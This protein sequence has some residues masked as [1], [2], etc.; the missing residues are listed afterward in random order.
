MS[1]TQAARASAATPGTRRTGA[2]EQQGV[3]S[4]PDEVGGAKLL[5][6]DVRTRSLLTGEARRR[7]V[8]RVFGVP[9][10][11]QSLLVT[12][13]LIGAVGTVLR[14]FAAALPRPRPSGADAAIGGSL[15]NATFR[16]IAGA[17]SRNMPLAGGLIAFAVLSHSLRPAVA[18]SARTAH[19]VAHEVRTVFGARYG[20]HLRPG[21]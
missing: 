8:T 18:G 1:A 11:D 10:A 15:L 3:A 19:A 4:K 9:R 5:F 2:R 17:P 12:V 7:G 16:G 14:G 6:V 13:I 20:R 21:P